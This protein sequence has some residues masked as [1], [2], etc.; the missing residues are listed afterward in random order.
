[1]TLRLHEPAHDTKARVQTAVVRIRDHRRNDSVVRA[2]IR[3]KYIRVIR[4]VESEVRTTVLQG[5][6]AAFRNDGSAEAGV[7]AND[8]RACVAFWV[9]G[10]EVDGVR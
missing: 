5:E 1:M 6:T 2:L 4:G 10:A 7:I 9:T 3:R 8:E